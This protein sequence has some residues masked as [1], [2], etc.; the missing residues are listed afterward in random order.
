[1]CP[2]KPKTFVFLLF[3]EGFTDPGAEDW[4]IWMA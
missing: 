3:T 2:P 4:T 1:M